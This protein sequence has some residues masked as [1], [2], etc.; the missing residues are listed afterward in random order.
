MKLKLIPAFLILASLFVG[1]ALSSHAETAAAAKAKVK[2]WKA[3]EGKIVAQSLVEA[4]L[5]SRT[6]LAS[7]TLHGVPPG[8]NVHTMFAG[9]WP[10]R[11][12]NADDPD[13]VDIATKAIA[14]LDPALSRKGLYEVMLPLKDASDKVIGALVI[15]FKKTD[16]SREG[17]FYYGQALEIQGYFK[18]R[19]PDLDSLFKNS[20]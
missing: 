15:G 8:T 12:G 6:D 2:N 3:P 18:S 11:V 16:P 5:A 1:T 10:E 9:S 4:L 14:V 7:V 20:V 19:T 17:L 13:D